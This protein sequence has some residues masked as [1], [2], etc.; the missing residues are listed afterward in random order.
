[1]AAL[2]FAAAIDAGQPIRVSDAHRDFTYVGDIVAGVIAMLRAPAVRSPV[3]N[4]GAGTVSVFCPPTLTTVPRAPRARLPAP[5][6]A[7][8]ALTP[9]PYP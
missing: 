6:R 2:Q 5:R 4:L 3:L 9:T 7:R 1:M 8:R